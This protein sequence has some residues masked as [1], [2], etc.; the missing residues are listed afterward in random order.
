MKSRK[1]LLLALI[2]ASLGSISIPALARPDVDVYLN[3]APPPPRYEVVPE[4]R[5]G[6]VWVPGYWDARGHRHVWA[7]GHWERARHGHYWREP[8]WVQ[9]DNGWV[10][11]RGRWL[12]DS[13]RDGVPDRYDRSPG[14]PYRQ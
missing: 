10:L 1:P 2:L 7:R 9:R 13:D 12:R 3:V 5:R 6:Y 14:N 8:R 11:E 4:P